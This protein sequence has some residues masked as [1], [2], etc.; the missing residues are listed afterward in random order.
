MITYI[1][2]TQQLNNCSELENAKEFQVWNIGDAVNQVDLL[3][4]LSGPIVDV[5]VTSDNSL[6]YVVTTK[7]CKNSFV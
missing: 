1:S 5:Q 2:K 6:A 3:D 4:K 7:P